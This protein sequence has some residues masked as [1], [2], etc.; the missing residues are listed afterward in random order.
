VPLSDPVASVTALLDGIQSDML[1]KG[2]AFL[3]ASTHEAID[4][5]TFQKDLDEKGGFFRAHFCGDAACEASI[6]EETKATIRCVPLEGNREKGTCL[7][8]GA[9]SGEWVYFA[10]AY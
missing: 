3:K 8:C 10:R 4:Y 6:K 7:R 1:E 9:P 2:R 5:A